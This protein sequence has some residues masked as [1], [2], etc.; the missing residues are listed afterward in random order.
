V[1]RRSGPNNEVIISSF[2]WGVVPHW[3]KHDDSTL[4]TINARAETVIDPS[5]G[6]SM[7]KS[8][9]G[10]KRCLVPIQGYYEW[11]VKGKTRLPH[12]TRHTDGGLM[13]A[14]GLWDSV[15]LEGAINHDLIG[16]IIGADFDGRHG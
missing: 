5:V 1:V 4:K 7:W 11:Q 10:K 8:L 14:A 13:L 6:G 9:R 2:R 12:Y 16:Y 3:A 15:S